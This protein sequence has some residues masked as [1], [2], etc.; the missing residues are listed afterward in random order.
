[1][2]NKPKKDRRYMPPRGEQDP[3]KRGNSR[4]KIALMV[5]IWVGAGVSRRTYESERKKRV[6]P[7][8]TVG[9]G[10]NSRQKTLWRRL[11]FWATRRILKNGT[12][13]ATKKGGED[14]DI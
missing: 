10:I 9:K 5:T 7:T 13:E 2:S 12:S 11:K 1:L 8:S 6:G 4:E 3:I 14:P